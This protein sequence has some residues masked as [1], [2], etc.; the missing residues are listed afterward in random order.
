[1]ASLIEDA[2]SAYSI[3]ANNYFIPAREPD[4][5]IPNLSKGSPFQKHEKCTTSFIANGQYI[6]N[7]YFDLP[8]STQSIAE[9]SFDLRL[10]IATLKLKV[11]R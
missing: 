6:V 10:N 1:M 9:I 5:P 2:L 11:L 7:I 4:K 8:P 3:E